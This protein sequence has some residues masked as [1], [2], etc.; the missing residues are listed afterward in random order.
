MYKIRSVPTLI[1]EDDEGVE[2]ARHT[3]IMTEDQ[4]KEWC[5]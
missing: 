5:K 1:K 2:V 3:G 4:L